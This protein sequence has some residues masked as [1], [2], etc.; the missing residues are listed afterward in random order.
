MRQIGVGE[1][2]R[3]DALRRV[4]DQQRAFAGRRA[5]RDFVGKV[6]VAGSV[7]QVELVG[8]AV[9]RACRSCARREP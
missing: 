1:R 2:L 7:D 3:L 6:D 8:L 4:H 9:L 5:A